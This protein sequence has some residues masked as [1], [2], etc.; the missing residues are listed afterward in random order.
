MYIKDMNHEVNYRL[1]KTV[2]LNLYRAGILTQTAAEALREKIK[3]RYELPIGFL[4]REIE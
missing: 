2:I 3:Q 1:A 4:D